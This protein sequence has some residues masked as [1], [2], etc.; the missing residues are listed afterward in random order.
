[1]TKKTIEYTTVSKTVTQWSLFGFP[2]YK[3]SQYESSRPYLKRT[4]GVAQATTPNPF[5]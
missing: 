2:I 5:L 3:T 4:D 1:M